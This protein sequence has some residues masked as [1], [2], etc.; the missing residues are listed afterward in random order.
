MRVFEVGVEKWLKIVEELGGTGIDLMK[1][2]LD[3]C[4]KF[5]NNKNISSPLN[6]RL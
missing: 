6:D 1:S 3:A 2:I 5:S 4:M